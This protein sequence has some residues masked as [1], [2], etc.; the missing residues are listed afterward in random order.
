MSDPDQGSIAREGEE[1]STEIRNLGPCVSA[2]MIPSIISFWYTFIL[3]LIVDN[4]KIL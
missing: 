4:D 2:L 1:W 3:A